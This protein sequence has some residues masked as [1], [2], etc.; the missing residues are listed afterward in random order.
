[1]LRNEGD[2]LT[3]V[4]VCSPKI[5]YFRVDDLKLHNITE[6]SDPAKAIEQHDKLKSTMSEFGCQ[7]ID[8]PELSNHPNSV[9]TMDTALCTP[10]GYIKLRMGLKTREGEE[11]WMAQHLETL[12]EP[13][14]GCIEPPGTVE[15]GDVILAGSVAFVGCSRR[16]NREGV[17]QISDLL[18]RMGYEVRVTTV[19]EPYLH[20]GGAMSMIG[21]ERVLCCKGV[22]PD[23]FFNGFEKIEVSGD[24][25]I[26]GNVINLGE[27]EVIADI[28][29]KEAIEK[30]EQA[31]FTIHALDLSEFVK[32]T[33]GPSCLI[34]PVE[35]K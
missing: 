12:G 31:N 24:T 23:D 7:V 34:M 11:E 13:Y 10:Q 17:R 28:R 9:F 3:R 27:N 8:I 26:S 35:R 32:G 14:A 29:N 21:P 16:T 5:E 4:V 2:R 33:G 30:L 22:F 20:I 25:F 1:M 18:K 19:P 15:G 6:L